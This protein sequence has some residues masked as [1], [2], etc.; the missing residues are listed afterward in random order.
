VTGQAVAL[1]MAGSAAFD[2][3]PRRSTVLQQP[4]WLR[5]MEC[6]VEPTLRCE[7]RTAMAFPAEGLVTV[8][9]CAV[10][11]SAERCIGMGLREV[12]SVEPTPPFTGVAVGAKARCMAVGTG[13]CTSAY[14]AAVFCRESWVVYPNVNSCLVPGL[15]RRCSSNAGVGASGSCRVDELDTWCRARARLRNAIQHVALPRR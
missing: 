9:G 12:G 11:L 5:C 1:G 10:A 8:A 7:S 3:L 13:K 14:R 2:P 4:Q 6:D 15:D